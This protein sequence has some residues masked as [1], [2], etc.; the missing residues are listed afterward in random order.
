MNEIVGGHFDALAALEGAQ[1]FDDQ[2]IVE[3]VGMIE[4]KG[5]DVGVRNELR[6]L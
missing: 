1:L 4:V 2:G 6:R 3:G 5:R